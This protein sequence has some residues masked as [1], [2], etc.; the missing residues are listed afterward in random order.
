M[1]SSSTQTV[2]HYIVKTKNCPKRNI[3]KSNHL[4]K[5]FLVPWK[6][7]HGTMEDWEWFCLYTWTTTIEDII[8]PNREECSNKF[9]AIF[10]N[11]LHVT[12]L[13]SCCLG[14]YSKFPDNRNLF[15]FHW[16]GN[17]LTKEIDIIMILLI[18]MNYYNRRHYWTQQGGVFQ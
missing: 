7:L 11:M 14:T 12:G 15:Q 3:N 13:S 10:V 2:S 5:S 4:L 6:F 8:G 17:L 9:A 18:Y 1:K 16:K